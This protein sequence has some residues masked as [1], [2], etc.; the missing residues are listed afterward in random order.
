MKKSK[1]KNESHFTIQGWMLNEL[2]LKGNELMIYAIIYGFSQDGQS[3]FTGSLQYLADWTNSTKQNC[4]NHLKSLM[5]KNLIEKEELEINNNKYCKYNAKLDTIQ[6]F[7]IGSQKN[8]IGIQKNCI[9]IQNFCTNNIDYNIDYKTNIDK[10][11]LVN[12]VEKEEKISKNDLMLKENIKCIIDYLNETANTKYRYNS[13]NTQKHIKARFDEGYILDDFYDVIDNKWKDWKNTEW[14]KYMRPETLFG[15]K[16]ENY[17]NGKVFNGKPK[18]SY[19]TK[20]SFD[21]TANHKTSPD[22]L[23]INEYNKLTFEEKK[24]YLSKLPIASMSAEQK[25]FFNQHCLA[26]DKN[27]NLIKF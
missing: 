6:N 1:I 17:L 10:S 22:R 24:N 13:K 11:I 8:C 4:M 18:T 2:K 15:S 21:N 7:C 16:F 5:D 27:G 19:G 14:E 23:S 20:P 25:E 12:N 9:G 3:K 26:R